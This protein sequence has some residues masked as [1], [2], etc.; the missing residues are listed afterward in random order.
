MCQVPSEKAGRAP[1]FMKQPSEGEDQQSIGCYHKAAVLPPVSFSLFQRSENIGS[2]Q[3]VRSDFSLTLYAKTQ[4]NFLAN[5]IAPSYTGLSS[6]LKKSDR[7]SHLY[8][9]I[10]VMSTMDAYGKTQHFKSHKMKYMNFF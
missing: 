6:K 5:P 1:G 3:K 4:M 7:R 10:V 9:I 8:V 2:G